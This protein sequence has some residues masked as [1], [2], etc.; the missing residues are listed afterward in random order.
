LKTISPT[1][2]SQG[3]EDRKAAH[4]AM[5]QRLAELGMQLAAHTAEEVLRH[6]PT[7]GAGQIARAG[8][9]P[10]LMFARLSRGVRE[11]LAL[12]ARIAA[13][14]TRGGACKESDVRCLAI[15]DWLNSEIATSHH[16]G[17]FGDVSGKSPAG[18]PRPN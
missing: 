10:R 3:A 8:A 14:R 12:K 9:D 15:L 1:G 13:G 18:G 16:R 2:I 6:P 4:I 7:G 5:L 17:V 11:T